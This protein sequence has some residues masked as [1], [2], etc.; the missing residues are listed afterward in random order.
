MPMTWDHYWRALWLA[1]SAPED[2]WIV[3]DRRRVRSI[4][5]SSWQRGEDS[6]TAHARFE[7]GRDVET[8]VWR[9]VA[10]PMARELAC[11]VRPKLDPG[12]LGLGRLDESTGAGWW[13][14]RPACLSAEVCRPGGFPRERDFATDRGCSGFTWR[15]GGPHSADW[16]RGL[17]ITAADFAEIRA[18]A[19]AYYVVPE[20]DAAEVAQLAAQIQA[21]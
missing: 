16:P 13:R 17:Q 20:E 5:V 2:V 7:A 10:V 3:E 1:T 21:A 6:S 19:F 11:R 14:G 12:Q 18:A 15:I 8:P 4:A 9:L